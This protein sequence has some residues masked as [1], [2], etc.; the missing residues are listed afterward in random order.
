MPSFN[1]NLSADALWSVSRRLKNVAQSIF[2]TRDFLNVSNGSWD[3]N[4]LIFV[5]VCFGI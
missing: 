3:C 4:C 1:M 5:E 2:A